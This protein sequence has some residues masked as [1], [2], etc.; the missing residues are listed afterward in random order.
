MK[1]GRCSAPEFV[2]FLSFCLCPRIREQRQT[3]KTATIWPATAAYR[4]ARSQPPAVA[5][6]CQGLKTAKSLALAM[7]QYCSDHLLV[8]ECMRIT[9]LR[10]YYYNVKSNTNHTR[11]PAVAEGPRER[12][13]G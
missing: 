2:G 13:V 1:I 9:V 5:A 3:D 4:L 6:F 8:L 10:L 12:A 7:E 11:S